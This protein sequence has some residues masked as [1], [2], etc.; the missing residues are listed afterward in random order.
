MIQSELMAL[1]VLFVG[2]SHTY[3]HYMP[4]MLVQL[5]EGAGRGIGLN[6]DQVTGEGAALQWHWNNGPTRERIRSRHWDYVVLQDRSGGPLEDPESFRTHARWLDGEIRRQGA[7]TVF[8]M[9]W[10]N[11]SRPDTQGI[12]ADAYATIAAEL[13]AVLA[14]VGLV[15]EKVQAMDDKIN[16]YH[17]DDRHANPI[18]A[19]L[20]ACV[21]YAVF[22]ETSPEGLP[23]TL[24]I[25]GKIRLDL[26]EDRAGFLQQIAY[27]SVNNVESIMRK[28]DR[29]TNNK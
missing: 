12:L 21:F 26:A 16:L 13:N 17:I 4:Q 7:Q 5:A 11:K 10:A 25:E 9:T 6:V 3:L 24:R 15:W 20:T 14:P 8:Y 1:N 22:L 18:G 2:N 27:D 19:Y 23:A 28:V 29:M